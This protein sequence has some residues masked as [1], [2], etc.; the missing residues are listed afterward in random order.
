MRI[1][2]WFGRRRSGAIRAAVSSGDTTTEAHKLPS[3]DTLS[4]IA[5]V[6]DESRGVIDVRAVLTVRKKMKEKLS[7]MVEDQVEMLVNAIGQGI[8]IQ[9]VSEEIDPGE[10][11]VSFCFL[12]FFG[13]LCSN[14]SVDS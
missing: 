9:L 2:S 12:R 3:D 14:Q 8:S 6:G 7:E 4:G 10:L 1:T 13:F 11:F 5:F